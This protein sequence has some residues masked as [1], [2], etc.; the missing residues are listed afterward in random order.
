VDVV[1]HGLAVVVAWPAIGLMVLGV[2]LG[3]C[4]GAVP[5]LGGIVGMSILLPFSFG[6]EP[7]AAFAFLLGMYAVTTTS[8]SLPAVLLGVPGTAAGAATVIDGYPMAQRGEA[9]R[10]LGAAFSVSALGGIL[11]AVALAASIPFVRPLILAFAPP[12]YFMLGVL[13]LSCVGAL[14][15][16]SLVKGLLGALLGL[17]LSTVGYS[18]EGGSPRYDF[19]MVYLLA[20]I[21]LVPMALGLFGLPEIIFLSGK[22]AAIAKVG[23]S[24]DRRHQMW[25][26]IKD[27][28]RNWGLVVRSSL[29]GI[30]VGLLPGGGGAVADW[31]AYGHAVQSAR[32]KSQF[33]KGDVRGVIAPEAANH[34]VKGSALLP[35]VAFGIPATPGLAVM[36]GAFLIH[37]LRPGPEML[38]TNLYLTIS[39]IWTLVIANILGAAALMVW[40]NQLARITFMRGTLI[41]PFI[42]LFVFMG[43]WMSRNQMGDWVALI[44]FGLVGYIFKRAGWPRPPVLLG[45]ILGPIMETNLDITYQVMGWGFVLRPIVAAMI[46]LLAAAAIWALWKSWRGRNAEK[47]AWSV[48]ISGA[49]DETLS[50][51][52][53]LIMLVVFAAALYTA[54]QWTP[55]ARFFPIVAMVP[56]VALTLSML[57]RD[58]GIWLRAG[59]PGFA[60]DTPEFLR[61]SRVFLLFFALVGLTLVL[62]QLTSV[63]LLV[64]AY[65][66]LWARERPAIA[67]GQ[68]AAAVVV[69][70]GLFDRFLHVVWYPSLLSFF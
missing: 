14:S 26:G 50:L 40:G 63:A 41:V 7:E 35:T 34:S 31:V 58:G 13:G 11:G 24:G 44:G 48:E 68:A 54:A 57:V 12:E 33:G 70:Y 47:T 2:L 59:R 15:G 9:T 21:P 55:E 67:F 6:M 61:N 53:A 32:D 28:F 43:A 8:D 30:Y 56:A 23:D 52:L 46:A 29:I 5:G 51:V 19:D 38:T 49:T 62:D 10:A 36:M 3:L 42:I 66:L 64:L 27:T 22:N 25:L 45:F 60:P 17:L 69:L 18:V 4:F 20:G 65:L 16:D 1:L 37:G 39:F